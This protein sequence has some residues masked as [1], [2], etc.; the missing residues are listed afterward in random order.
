M[1]R[2]LWT[3]NKKSDFSLTFYFNHQRP[4]MTLLPRKWM[5]AREDQISTPFSTDNTP[6]YIDI[7][8]SY[9]CNNPNFL[10][11]RISK[12]SSLLASSL[13]YV[14]TYNNNYNGINLLSQINTCIYIKRKLKIHIQMY[15]HWVPLRISLLQ[16]LS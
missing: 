6:L 8:D 10:T 9:I 5:M 1:C 12:F 13:T 11:C 7:I 4:A 2:I 3:E 16:L 15:S 14:I